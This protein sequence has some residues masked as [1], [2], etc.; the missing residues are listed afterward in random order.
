MDTNEIN[1]ENVK[2]L[3]KLGIDVKDIANIYVIVTQKGQDI[4]KQK[5][6]ENLT[7]ILK[8]FQTRNQAINDET[9]E[10]I[11]KEDVIDMIQKNKKLITLDINKKIKPICKTLDS[12][13]FMTESDTNKLIKKN[14][15]IFNVS[16]LDLEIYATFLSCF[17]IKIDKSIVNLFEYI[18]KQHSEL[19]NHDVQEIYQRLCYIQKMSNSMLITLEDFSNLQNVKF[20]YQG[21]EILD[22][23]DIFIREKLDFLKEQNYKIYPILENNIK[24]FLEIMPELERKI[25]KMEE[26]NFSKKQIQ[27]ILMN[28]ILYD[29]I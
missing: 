1:Q 24:I 25:K 13:Y 4:S 23:N 21:K 19:L 2:T 7:Q 15:N 8:Y 28:E 5:F 11:Y 17:A 26:K 12:Y 14:P 10:A 29:K 27:M 16:Q 6:I 20:I 18:I 3:V 22:E 9:Q